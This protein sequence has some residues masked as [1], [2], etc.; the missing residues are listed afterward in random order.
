MRT[1]TKT[2]GLS[3]LVVAGAVGAVVAAC[4]PA[5]APL[6]PCPRVP[7]DA[8]VPADAS[9]AAEGLGMSVVTCRGGEYGLVV[10]GAH[11]RSLEELLVWKRRVEGAL[12]GLGG[13]TSVGLGV[14]CEREGE[15]RPF[16]ARGCVRVSLDQ[17]TPASS[18]LPEAIARLRVDD[19]DLRVS[20]SQ[21]LPRVPRCAPSDS[22]CGALPYEGR[23]CVDAE[24]T[25]GWTRVTVRTRGGGPCEHDGEC[26][27]CNTV[28]TDYAHRPHECTLELATGLRDAYCGCVE[29]SCRWF[30]LER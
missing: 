1:K 16:D 17:G 10:P 12:F 13:V 9:R 22:A 5:Q 21:G 26:V 7:F 19:G 15:A 11:E 25:R 28:C 23:G 6:V 27:S 18:S 3:L 8:R 4:V 14:C 2:R 30:E 29:A 24:A 20:V